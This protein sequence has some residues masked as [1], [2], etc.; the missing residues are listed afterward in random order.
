MATVLVFSTVKHHSKV[1]TG[2][3]SYSPSNFSCAPSPKAGR[4]CCCSA[5]AVERFMNSHKRLFFGCRRATGN[6]PRSC[7]SHSISPCFLTARAPLRVFFFSLSLLPLL[8]IWT[9][10]S[11]VQRGRSFASSYCLRH[12]CSAVTDFHLEGASD[13]PD[14]HPLHSPCS[15]KARWCE[16]TTNASE[17][18]VCRWVCNDLVHLQIFF[19]S[20]SF[21]LRA[22]TFFFF[23]SSLFVATQI[24]T[25]S[26]R[27]GTDHY[28]ELV[29]CHAHLLI[30]VKTYTRL[31]LAPASNTTYAFDNDKKAQNDSDL[32]TIYN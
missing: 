24:A 6:S 2:V 1:S 22:K 16:W 14:Q 20:F 3:S 25:L 21:T 28:R 13:L 5:D 10:R 29:W 30:L 8:D 15:K 12:R 17:W 11:I 18:Y 31:T 26:R 7:L 27:K 19:F 9:L 23:L 4:F 32:D